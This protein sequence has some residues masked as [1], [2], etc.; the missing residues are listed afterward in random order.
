MVCI[1]NAA[2]KQVNGTRR[3]EREKERDEKVKIKVEN[4]MIIIIFKWLLFSANVTLTRSG[5]EY[6]ECP[7]TKERVL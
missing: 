5:L 2:M 1:E 7:S 4:E 6:T 3:E